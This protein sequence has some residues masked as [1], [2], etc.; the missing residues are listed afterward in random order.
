ML[1][2]F[3]EINE[4][5]GMEIAAKRVIVLSS[6]LLVFGLAASLTPTT[7]APART[8]Q[9]MEDNLPQRVGNFSYIRSAEDPDVSY[10]MSDMAYEELKP[11]GIVARVFEKDGKRFDTVV[12]AANNRIS[13]HEPTTCFPGQNWKILSQRQ[14]SLETQKRN[15]VNVMILDMDG[16]AGKRLALYTFRGPN[17]TF[18]IRDHMFWD[19]FK[20]ELKGVRPEGSLMRVMT[21]DPFTSEQELIEFATKWFDECEVVS[22]GVY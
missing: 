21:S 13:L 19:W 16:E 10:R 5:A 8:E 12:V 17:G 20:A 22:K 11:Y 4:G 9:W 14:I 7:A 18:A 6:L 15:K 2:P 1:Y 3:D